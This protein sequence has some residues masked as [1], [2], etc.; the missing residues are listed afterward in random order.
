MAT[1]SEQQ[2]LEQSVLSALVGRIRDKFREQSEKL[3]EEI[4]AEELA[5]VTISIARMVI[6]RFEGETLRIE[7]VKTDKSARSLTDGG[8]K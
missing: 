7:I 5:T 2:G 3:Y 1:L 6:F 4:I 8:K